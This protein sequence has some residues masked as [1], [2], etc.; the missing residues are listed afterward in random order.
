[1]ENVQWNLGKSKQAQEIIF[2]RNTQ[3]VVHPPAVFNNMPVGRSSCQKYLGIYL[4][5]KL[6]FS[7]HVEKN[8]SK[9]NKDI[10]VLRKLCNILPRNYLIAI[11]KSFIRPQLD[12]GIIIFDQQIE[13]V[14]YNAAL[15]ITGTIQGTS[16]EKVYKELGL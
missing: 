11:Y 4:D 14:Q 2:C 15:A 7:N 3:K 5:E 12:Y 13:S 8:I 6:S 9:A 16:R 10:G 1:M